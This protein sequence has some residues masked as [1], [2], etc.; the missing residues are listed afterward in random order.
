MRLRSLCV[1]TSVAALA[2]PASLATAQQQAGAAPPPNP[3]LTLP[4]AAKDAA[5]VSRW[6][7]AASAGRQLSLND[8]L[9]W[10]QIRTPQISNDGNWLVYNVGPNEG[11]A[12]V[13]MRNTAVNGK[14]WRFPVGD[15]AA[16]NRAAPGGGGGGPGG[17]GAATTLAVSGNNRWVA[18][19]IYPSSATAQRGRGRPAGSAGAGAAGANAPVPVKL[20]IVSLADGARREFENVRSFRFAGDKSDWLAVH[21]APPASSGASGGGAGGGGGSGASGGSTTGT[22]LEL[23]NL[24]AGASAPTTPIAN[25]SEFAF[26]DGADWIAY[27]IAIQD[28]LGNSIQ[29][30]QLS[31]GVTR[32]LDAH[33]AAYR[34]ITWGDSSDALA[35]IRVVSDTAGPVD[36]TVTAL[37]WP[38]AGA[39]APAFT[40]DAN[41]AGVPKGLVLSG[42]Y[43]IAFGR[44][45]NVLY[46]GLREPRPPRPRNANFNGTTPQGVAPGGGGNTGRVAAAAQT[47]AD[48][49]SLVLWHWK[50]PR[51]QATQQV[52]ENADRAAAFV[53]AYV[54]GPAK[55]VRLTDENL[56]NL[57]RGPRDTWA[58][59][60]D[61]S[62]YE[63]AAGIKGFQYRDLYAVNVATGE[64][65]LIQ[66]KVPGGAGGGGGFGGGG[67]VSPFSPD[68]GKYAYYDTGD[69]KAYDFTTGA[70]K[71]ITAGVN[72]KFWDVEDDHNQV[73]PAIPGGLL[74]WTRDGA[75]VIVRDNW[76][77]WRLPVSSGAAVNITANGQRDQTPL[78]AAAHLRFTRSPGNRSGGTAVRRDLRRAH[79]EGRPRPGRR[80]QGRRESHRA[81][82][83][84]GGLPPGARRQHVGVHAPDD[85]ALP[86]LV[87]HGRPEERAP[88]H[89]R[90][91]AAEG[92]RVDTGRAPHRVR[93]ARTAAA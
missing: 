54:I 45:A 67:A 79:Q 73:K 30:R 42:D 13:V 80:R 3:Q 69:W 4:Y 34:R 18:F 16:A 63:R 29:L 43:S 90:Q 23:V 39:S 82:Q 1:A 89:R 40:I 55:V 88:S 52:Q 48:V 37:V 5:P 14:E 31:T 77:L 51:T 86:G 93:R 15:A 27:A 50:D 19:L 49:P 92:H 56:R 47:D 8:L 71:T 25:V 75:S 32:S 12:E 60:T 81:R 41:T 20:G 22:T 7:P 64:R 62:E 84:Q 10:K 35:A 65:K 59:A 36:E 78:S 87:R 58:V 83:R 74:G 21:H 57:Q 44:N 46:V 6:T 11:D 17:G 70:T 26:D 91:P 9:A 28:Q 33:K 68:N 66:K 72:G 85:H 61:V 2:L 38:H 76:D 53:A 24:A